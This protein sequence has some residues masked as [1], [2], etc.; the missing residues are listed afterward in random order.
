MSLA[1][2]VLKGLVG[3]VAAVSALGISS[4]CSASKTITY[5]REGEQYVIDRPEQGDKA[6]VDGL[7]TTTS[8]S[9][10]AAGLVAHAP[11][12]GLTGRSIGLTQYTLSGPSRRE[13]YFFVATS[14]ADTNNNGVIEFPGEFHGMKRD[15]SSNEPLIF[16]GRFLSWAGEDAQLSIRGS[17]TV[18]GK[19]VKLERDDQYAVWEFSPGTLPAGSYTAKFTTNPWVW[20]WNMPFTIHE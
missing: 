15:F 12:A 11:I 3:T 1:Q 5:S 6:F 2:K 20:W 7:L 14:Y 9:L 13:P 10:G 17:S 19:P 4:G 18:T 16:G 8:V